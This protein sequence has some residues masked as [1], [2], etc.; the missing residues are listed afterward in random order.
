MVGGFQV[1]MQFFVYMFVYYVIFGFNVGYVYVFW[2]I[3]YWMYKWYSQYLD[4]IMK[5]GSM[6]ML[7]LIV[8]LLGVVVV[9]V[10]MFNSLKVNEYLYGLVCWVEKKDIQVVGL[11]LCECNVLEIVIGKVVFMVIGVYVGGW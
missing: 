1:V 11:L 6:G 5:V 7:V 10:V 4:E 3:L 9:K 8:G 2:L